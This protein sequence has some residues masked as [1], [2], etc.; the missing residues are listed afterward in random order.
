MS[1]ENFYLKVK[2]FQKKTAN[3]F[4]SL[5][6]DDHLCDIILV[7]D[8]EIYIPAHKVILSVSSTFFS[9]LI[10]K[11]NERNPLIYL[12]GVKSRDLQ[13]ILSYIYNGQVKVA[14]QELDSF[15][16]V[17]KRLKID[18]L[19]Q[20]IKCQDEEPEPEEDAAL[21]P[22]QKRTRYEREEE[23]LFQTQKR[24]IYDKFTADNNPTT[25]KNKTL[26]RKQSIRENEIEPVASSR[27]KSRPNQLMDM[28]TDQ[29]IH[30]VVD[31]LFIKSG[32]GFVCK[33]CGVIFEDKG[34]TELHFEVHWGDLTCKHCGKIY[35]GKETPSNHKHVYTF[36]NRFLNQI[37]NEYLVDDDIV[38][39]PPFP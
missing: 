14:H 18:G 28:Q 9:G 19:N 38:P 3:Y 23:G 39:Y 37:L 30:N 16:D 27:Q 4:S 8:D 2:D 7:S 22:T 26:N 1:E 36:F 29:G 34:K 35:G 24:N 17:G 10:R 15:L 6:D 12:G 31:D 20:T 32:D 13:N 21:R 25:I 11:F 5:K 33:K